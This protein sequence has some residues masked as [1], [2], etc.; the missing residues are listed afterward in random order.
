MWITFV[1][2]F[3][4]LNSRNMLQ[5]LETPVSIILGLVMIIFGLNKFL[6]FIAVEPP[7]DP[8]AQAFMGAMFSSYLYIVVALG[9]I[10]GGI[11]LLSPR[12]RLLGTVII[13]AIM[14]NIVGFHIAHDLP[15]NG[16]W[17]LPTILSLVLCFI[18]RDRL[19]LLINHNVQS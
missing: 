2:I 8:M 5:K 12:F 14:I 18:L 15:G 9:E 19:S 10:M 11:F 6:G 1:D 4:K 13:G 7:A 17:L 3:I 16:I